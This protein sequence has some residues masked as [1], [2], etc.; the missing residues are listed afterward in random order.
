MNK[1][2]SN[3]ERKVHTGTLII[4]DG[5]D[6][7]GKSTVIQILTDYL[8]VRGKNVFELK[9]Y[10]KHYHGLPQPEEL[11]DYDF[12]ISAEP[13]YSL[14]G[15]AIRDEFIRQS[16]RKYSAFTT[17]TA[18]ALDRL[19]LY[20]RIII[21]LLE[22]GKTIIQDRGVTTS[23]VYQPIQAEPLQLSKVLSLE[24]NKLAMQH[25][26]DLLIIADI[27]PELCI[28][29]LDKRVDK[30]DNVIF[31]NLKFQ[32]KAYERFKSKWFAQLFTRRGSKVVYLDASKTKEE[33]M[34]DA[35][36]LYEEFCK[37]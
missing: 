2:K 21:P 16:K 9:E 32:K 35:I 36:K 31:E 18:Y 26:P 15:G 5:L 1:K 12:I 37:K 34:S 30:K 33:I 13:T 3:M 25:R 29:R 20:K 28:E 10:W 24:G 11:Y 14:V 4:V 17:A 27:A 8:K 22:K 6:G 19:I 7:S 23:I